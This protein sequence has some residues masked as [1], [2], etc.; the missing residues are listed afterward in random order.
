M[1]GICGF[2]FEDK[3]LLKKMC[4]LIKHR[5]PDDEGYYVDSNIS[6]GIRRLSIID[7]DTGHQPQYNE[8]KTIWIIF[9]GEIYNFLDL[10]KD[11]LEKGHIFYTKSDTE[12]IIHAYEEWGLNCFDRLRGAFAISIYNSNTHELILARDPMGLKPLYYY[13][14]ET[15]FIFASEI[16]CIL[17][18]KIQK[19]LDINA[20]NHYISLNYAYNNKTLFKNISK[21]PPS[22]YLV[23]NLNQNEFE[24]NKY[25]NL[26]FSMSNIK[27]EETLANELRKLLEESI[28]IRL[29]SDVPLGAFLSGG[30]DSSSVVA[31]MSKFMQDPVKTFS[32]GFEKGAPVNETKYAK[33]V[34]EAFGT[35]HTELLI[36]SDCYNIIPELTWHYDDL[37]SDPAIIPVYFMSKYAK[38]KITV[39]LTGDGADEIFAGYEQNYWLTRK[40]YFKLI[41]KPLL[42]PI[43]KLYKFIPSHKMQIAFAALYS[44]VTDKDSFFK[45]L[46]IVKDIEKKTIFTYKVDSV[47][48]QLEENLIEGLDRINQYIN[49]DLFHQLPNLYNMKTDKMSMAASLEARAPLL[50]KEIVKW[51]AKIP[52]NLKLKGTTEKYILRLAMKDLLPSDILNRKKL[53]FGTPIKLWLETG[54]KESSGD[55]LE[56]LEKRN[57]IINPK[58]VKKVKNNRFSILY[59]YRVWNLMMFEIWYETFMENDGLKPIKY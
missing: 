35:E 24:I 39:A 1:C 16:K 52:T 12:I 51:A 9:N 5:G 6:I 14:D 32:I 41:P 23:L 2:N 44:S 37:I 36:K 29:I 28:K 18:H 4:D 54:M 57:N 13:F 49:Y 15:M 31:L 10:K 46:L 22:S 50:D 55:L 33:I 40:N 19:E 42:Y 56:K 30:I 25:W 59:Q 8:D 11:L 58:Y 38:D 20:L 26:D 27:S 45:P 53:G 3:S 17:L 43:K 21:V 7:L 47:Q 48:A 34:S